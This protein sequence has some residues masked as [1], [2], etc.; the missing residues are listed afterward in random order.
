M[1]LFGTDCIRCHTTAAWTPAQLTRHTFPL[2]HGDEGQIPCLTCH[3]ETYADYTCYN[4]HEHERDETAEI[5]LDEGITEFEDC[6]AC[7]PTGLEEEAE[8]DD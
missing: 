1:G 5:H 4:C 2:D 8:R 3:T 6:V 7:H